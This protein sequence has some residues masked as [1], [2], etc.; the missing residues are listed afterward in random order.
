[1][2]HL[3]EDYDGPIHPHAAPNL[4]PDTAELARTLGVQNAY[5]SHDSQR[6]REVPHEGADPVEAECGD[7]PDGEPREENQ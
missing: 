7:E 4:S 3:I 1:M 5:Q 6:D 2:N